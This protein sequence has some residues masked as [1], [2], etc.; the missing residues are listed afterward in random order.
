[1]SSGA[2]RARRCRPA[3]LATRLVVTIRRSKTDQDGQ[4][5]EIAV[6]FVGKCRLCAASGVRDWL[7]AAGIVDGPVFDPEI[8]DTVSRTA[9]KAKP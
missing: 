7:K 3:V 4:G 5:R 2:G 8:E 6:P 9:G 1:M